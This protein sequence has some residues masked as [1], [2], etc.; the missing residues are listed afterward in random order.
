MAKE[1]KKVK[2]IVNVKNVEWKGGTFV[3]YKVS[4][5]DK[6]YDLR[7]TKVCPQLPKD[8][9]KYIV[10]TDSNSIWV[11]KRKTD[12]LGKE[13]QYP[14]YWIKSFEKVEKIEPKEIDGSYFGQV[15]EG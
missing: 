3:A 11:D 2:V 10:T 13:R 12:A 14:L 7:L 15:M 1:I 8:E 4:F 6:Y 9:G 5:G